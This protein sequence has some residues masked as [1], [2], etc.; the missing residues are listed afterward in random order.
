MFKRLK[1]EVVYDNNWIC[2]HKDEVEFSDGAVREYGV[3]RHHSRSV[4]VV[5]ESNGKFLF[6]NANRYVTNSKS[7]EMPSGI[8]EAGESAADAAYRE[9]LEETGCELIDCTELFCYYPSNGTSDQ[10]IHVAKGK[11]VDVDSFPDGVEVSSTVW[12]S[13]EEISMKILNNVIDDGPTIIAWL[14]SM[15]L[16]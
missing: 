9:V 10:I 12:L 3:V 6:V 2:V 16:T 1:T 15:F 11:T 13:A 4:V 5:V 8:I 7:L 14:Y